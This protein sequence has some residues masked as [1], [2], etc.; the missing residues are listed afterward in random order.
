MFNLRLSDYTSSKVDFVLDIAVFVVVI[1]AVPVAF[2]SHASWMSLLLFPWR[3]ACLVPCF[4][5]VAF[6]RRRER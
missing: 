5:E 1:A 3:R 6:P 4:H 2:E